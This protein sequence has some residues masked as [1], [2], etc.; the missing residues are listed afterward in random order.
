[1]RLRPIPDSWPDGASDPGGE[2]KNKNVSRRDLIKASVALSAAGPL[3]AGAT[4]GHAHGPLGDL[5]ALATAQAIRAGEVTAEHVVEDAIRRAQ[6]MQPLINAIV[7]DTFERAR[8]SARSRPSGPLAG[9]P[10]FI[11][12]LDDVRGVPTHS[13]SRSFGQRP[14]TA[15]GPYVD[16]LEKSGVLI[17]GKSATP[18]FGL[19]S[20]T[21]PI[22]GGPCRNPWNTAHSPGGSSGG[23]A[24]LVAARVVPIAHATDG[25]GSIRV[26]A[27]CCGVFGL[28][29]SRGRAVPLGRPIGPVDIAISHA[30]S[31][32]VRD[33]ALWLAATER[34]GGDRLFAPLGFI[35][36]PAKRRLRIA[37]DCE[38]LMG[39][40]LD[41]EVRAAVED[42]ARR[43]EALGHRVEN[44]PLPLAKREFMDAFAIYW[45][46]GAAQIADALETQLGRPVT[47]ADLEPWTLGLRR[48]FTEHRGGLEAAIGVLRA[49]VATC[50]EFFRDHDLLLTPTLGQLPPA[51]GQLGPDV[52]FQTYLE[53]LTAFVGFTPVQNAAGEPA[54]SVPLHW[55][56]AGLPIGS[57][58]AARAGDERTLLELAYELEAAH[59]WKHRRPP[60]CAT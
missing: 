22:F 16:A 1:L 54:M 23:A 15:Q 18:E 24:A 44:A 55:S 43:C 14:A 12:D 39:T 33:S 10:T 19:T 48:H 17:L 9:V 37:L 6:A 7:T 34:T 60:V 41:P 32:S 5:D 31:I 49:S 35:A 56:K 28:K 40:A 57:H 38:T 51:I 45:A 26:P 21:E 2:L 46:A 13:G 29:P 20:T 27:S 11:K 30:A 59:P 47:E 50:E 36:A 25:G 52:S 8:T 58:F 3:A 4:P 53:R 42:T